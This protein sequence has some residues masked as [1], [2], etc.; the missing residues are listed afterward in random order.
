[1]DASIHFFTYAKGELGT[2]RG[3]IEEHSIFGGKDLFV[4]EG[5]G[6]KFVE[7]LVL[8]ENVTVLA[9]TDA[10]ELKTVP[11]TYKN[12][13]PILKVLYKQLGL[14]YHKDENGRSI[15][16]QR[17]LIKLD[18]TSLR[19]HELWEP[20]LRKAKIMAW[21]DEDVEKELFKVSS[22]NLL[23]LMKRG[24]FKDLF[25]MAE[26]YGYAWTYNHVVELLSELIHYRALR[27]MGYDENKCAKELGAPERSR[28]ARELEAANQMLTS[29]DL[30]DLTDRV[31][32]FDTLA[33]RNPKLGFSLFVLNSPIRVR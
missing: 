4:L 9:E 18:W 22:G 3:I 19:S 12:K 1:M 20:F 11:Y 25:A 26:K 30:A 15:L 13:R 16:T 7:S 28:R 10:G 31:L 5:F 32:S 8:S 24:Q 2:V 6:S 29:S 17:G 33:L 27:V 14:N 21:S 23:T